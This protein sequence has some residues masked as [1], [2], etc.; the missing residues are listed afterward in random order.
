MKIRLFLPSFI[1]LLAV[2]CTV[3]ETETF[4]T[5]QPKD[6]VF[7]ASLESS[8]PDTKVFLDKLIKI[9]WDVN[10]QISIFN[11][12]TLNQQFMFDGEE[13]ANSGTF[14]WIDNGYFGAGNDLDYICA[15]YPYRS[16]EHTSELQSR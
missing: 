16:E 7:Y 1:C 10:D 8:E 12:S 14:H 9:L 13:P 3:Q 6:M 4:V 2:S 11:K 5:P 15:V